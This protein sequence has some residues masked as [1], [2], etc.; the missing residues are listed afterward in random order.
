MGMS[1]MARSTAVAAL[2]G[3]G[4][5][6]GAP[7]GPAAAAVGVGFVS[8]TLTVTVTGN[9]SVGLS[10]VSG[11]VR[12]AA[13]PPPADGPDC[14]EVH[15]IVV[16]GDGGAQFV[17]LV[18]VSSAT[19][20]N[21]VDTHVNLGGGADVL[22]T[23]GVT[24]VVDMGVGSDLVHAGVASSSDAIALGGNA[25]DVLAVDGTGAVEAMTASASGTSGTVS[26]N[27]SMSATGSGLAELVLNGG[28]ANDVLDASSMPTD[29]PIHVTL[30]G[31]AGD[32]QLAG[33]PNG[34]TLSGGAG[35]D[36]LQGGG[37]SDLLDGGPGQD[38]ML[39]G[40][41]SDTFQTDFDQRTFGGDFIHDDDAQNTFDAYMTPG[42]AAVR[43]RRS[44]GWSVS[45]GLALPGVQGLPAN[46][47]VVKVHTDPV[48]PSTL[49]DRSV[50]DLRL[51]PGL[52]II[53]PDATDIVDLTVG[54]GYWTRVETPKGPRVT[55]TMEQGEV[56]VARGTLLIHAPWV[57]RYESF[58][59]RVYRD[60]LFRFIPASDRTSL[61]TRLRTGATHP[62]AVGH[63]IVTSREFFGIEVDR[64]YTTY[65]RRNPD[66]AGRSS[67]VTELARPSRISMLRANLLG[68]PEYFTRFGMSD[69]TRWVQAAYLDI[70]GRDPDAAGL[71]H[72]T[73]RLAAGATRGSVANDLLS[74]AEA[75]GAV[76]AH[77]FLRFAG[78]EPSAGEKTLWSRS[79]A[80]SVTGEQDLAVWLVSGA[81]YVERD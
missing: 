33:G 79:L 17:I 69:N 62:D 78:R 46:I 48:A 47:A 56:D 57:D 16:T 11:L 10:C 28:G 71:D 53:T 81:G 68:S 52:Q 3:A 44:G 67:W 1:R 58:A 42:D 43:V 61:A 74:S 72:W 26:T 15:H 75:R 45:S 59:H 32:D 40:A 39:G 30:Q 36:A 21:L 70:F 29:S 50:I 54:S 64:A 14:S 60:L 8:D 73:G 38:D 27:S 23:S 49:D 66:A 55:S 35:D 22:Y 2:L 24:D 63:A 76:V 65:L 9:D 12:V 7:A 31:G 4:L 25:G 41:G 51:A 6:L 13:N 34:D 18:L 77:Q 19:F 5:A 80:S 20:P 37:G